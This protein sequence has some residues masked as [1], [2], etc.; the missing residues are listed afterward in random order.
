MTTRF[1]MALA[2][3]CLA[4]CRKPTT[5]TGPELASADSFVD[6]VG[7]NTH[8]SYTDS[9]YYQ[10]FALVK[11]ALL[12]LKIRH[13]RDGMHTVPSN[14]YA[15]HNELGNA[16]LKCLYVV[17]P[18]LANSVIIGYP[19]MVNN[20][21]A[22]ENANEAD[23]AGGTGWVAPLQSSVSSLA[24][25]G[26]SMHLPV[27]GPSLINQ[28]WWN[29]STNSYR[30]LGDI[31]AHVTFNN[32][33]NY[34]G[35]YHPE[36]KGWGGGCANG[37]CYGSI[38]WN[39]G[40]AQISG[41][42]RP[43]WTT[44]NG[45]TINPT[46]PGSSLPETVIASYLPR[47]LFSQWNAGI[48]RTYIYELADDPSTACCMGLM[49]ATGKRRM[50]FTA[51]QNLLKLLADPGKPFT[52]VPLSYS[53]TG[54]PSTLQHALLE[55]RDKTYWLALWQGVPGYDP[56]AYKLI[57]NAPMPITVTW[58]G[59]SGGSRIYKFG[60]NGGLVDLGRHDG[61][62]VEVNVDDNLLIVKIAM[63]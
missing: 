47:L 24:A 16:G 49:D 34:M 22:L 26:E 51:L 56:H 21:E 12:D 50:P 45:Y 38:P 11:Q 33:H 17:D 53:I 57:N 30:M 61:N 39:M 7:V 43:T 2:L 59:K 46:K 36:S 35:S 58:Q 27:V 48:L 13:Y 37:Y 5:V 31:S 14:I 42:G 3:L 1:V 6:S 54:A 28:N 44:E 52:L 15:L 20:M 63:S 32:L 25:L 8:F 19:Q 4:S 55:K 41:P 10:Q 62:S 60:T 9:I 23:A 40:Q 29:D 18:R